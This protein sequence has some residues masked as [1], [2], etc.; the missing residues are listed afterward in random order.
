MSLL[1]CVKHEFSE[2][3]AP[4]SADST[5]TLLRTKANQNEFKER[6]SENII[7]G[8]CNTDTTEENNSVTSEV[9]YVLVCAGI[10]CGSMCAPSKTRGVEG[11][12]EVYYSSIFTIHVHQ[13]VVKHHYLA[14]SILF[15]NWLVVPVHW[16]V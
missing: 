10:K 6:V 3:C 14:V 12:G 2:H 9:T 8:I 7:A 11:E 4:L 15:I 5:S 1:V 16:H 13:K